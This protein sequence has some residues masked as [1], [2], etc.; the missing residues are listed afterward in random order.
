MDILNDFH[1]W[2]LHEYT[3]KQ[4]FILI[5][6]STRPMYYTNSYCLLVWFIYMYG[7]FKCRVISVFRFMLPLGSFSKDTV[8]NQCCMIKKTPRWIFGQMK[9]QDASDRKKII[10]I[11]FEKK[12]KKV[13]WE[14]ILKKISITQKLI[15]AP[16]YP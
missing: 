1:Y 12:M 14:V 15:L 11:W 7:L 13:R 4:Y 8:I 9:R 2:L 10:R 3:K 6:I 16:L 5:C